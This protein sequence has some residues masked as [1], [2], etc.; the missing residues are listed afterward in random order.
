MLEVRVWIRIQIQSF[1][2][3]KWKKFKADIFKIFFWSK[4]QFTYP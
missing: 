1:D 2:D 4:M 3:Q